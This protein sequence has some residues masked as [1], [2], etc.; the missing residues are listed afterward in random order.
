MAIPT[1]TPGTPSP[2]YE[3]NIS[4][5]ESLQYKTKASLPVS[6]GGI[7]YDQYASATKLA[8]FTTAASIFQG[9]PSAVG[10]RWIPAE[11]LKWG[12]APGDGP[13]V[14]DVAGT[15]IRCVCWGD[16]QA[17]GT[18]TF[19]FNFGLIQ[20]STYTVYNQAAGFIGVTGGW[21]S[22]FMMEFNYQIRALG[23]ASTASIATFGQIRLPIGSVAACG[24]IF[25][26]TVTTATL[27]TSNPVFIDAK[28]AC[29][30]S[31]ASN[32]VTVKGAYFQILN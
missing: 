31:N 23:A 3:I 1:L 5:T 32:A 19:T 28:V 25:P 16:I 2:A 27:D 22:P 10:S 14:R 26:T 4:S 8:S 20:G 7:F 29:D 15:I 12:G 17:T 24:E 6:L 11:A 18:P 13:G 9:S 30:T 21:T